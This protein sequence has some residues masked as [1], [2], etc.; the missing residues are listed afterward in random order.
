MTEASF[1]GLILGV[2]AREDFRHSIS[3]GVADKK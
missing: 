3:A 1:Y 2:D